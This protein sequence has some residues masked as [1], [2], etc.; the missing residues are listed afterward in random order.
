MNNLK[1]RP[2][3]E[4]DWIGFSGCESETPFIVEFS[5]PNFFLVIDGAHAEAHRLVGDDKAYY[6]R[7]EFSSPGMALAAAMSLHGHESLTQVSKAWG[8]LA[9]EDSGVSGEL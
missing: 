9:I 5:D 4:S 6:F 7:A 3:D 1:I 8:D 2:F